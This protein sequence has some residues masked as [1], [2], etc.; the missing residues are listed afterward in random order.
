ML[1]GRG[2]QMIPCMQ[3]V[4]GV[5]HAYAEAMA[6]ITNKKFTDLQCA[7][8]FINPTAAWTVEPA[9]YDY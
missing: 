2:S 7:M 9:N 5:T 8:R 3:V 1:R 6:Q 4:I